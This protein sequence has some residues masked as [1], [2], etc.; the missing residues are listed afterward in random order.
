MF[1]LKSRN[2]LIFLVVCLISCHQTTDR[3]FDQIEQELS[4][5]PDSAYTR[6]S[7][8]A[9]KDLRPASRRARYALLMS[10]AMDKSYIDT[11]DD[12]LVQVAVNY[13]QRFGNERE[14]MLAYYSL[15]RVQR[16]AGK[17]TE[18]IITFLHTKDLA[19]SISDLHYLGLSTRNIA[20]LYGECN[21]EDSELQ[22]YIQSSDAFM[23]CGEVYYAAYSQLGEAR[24]YMAKGLTQYADS[25]LT[26]LEN[27]A[28]E[29]D[30][31]LLGLVLMDCALNLMKVSKGNAKQVIKLY[32]EADSLKVVSKKTVDYG[33]VAL[34]FEQLQKPDSADYY[35]TMARQTAKT[36][37]DST[38]LFNSL[39]LLYNSRR[40]YKT[41]NEHLV[42]GLEIH[43]Q[44]VYKK[45]NQQVAN[46]I[47]AHSQQKAA[48]HAEVA[49]YRLYLVFLSLLAVFAL[50]C[51][52][53]LVTKARRCQIREKNRIILEKE[54]RIDE[55]LANVQEISE[56]LQ[57]L[58]DNQSEMA[59]TIKDLMEEKIAIVKR[60][61]DA[62]ERVKNEPKKNPRDPY[63]YLDEDPLKKQTEEMQSFLNAL[64][65]IR[66][67]DTLFGVLEESV[68]KWRGDLMKKLRAACANNSQL[69]PK[70]SDDDLRILMLLYAGI[71]DRTIAF[72]MDM[73]CSAI[74]TR[75]SR[76]KER[77]MQNDIPDGL[78]FLQE[79]AQ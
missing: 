21:D 20:A 7:A 34:A 27:Y 56:Q 3:Q 64:N 54:Q 14:K 55:E 73:T 44:L 41:A 70:F 58:R 13:Y 69:R 8:I 57:D 37:L 4:F 51:V 1:L 74:R 65:Q 75:K 76:Y 63:R 77:L 33:T 60:C 79:L 66:K 45:E 49:R 52:L 11:D 43:N 47:S 19:E 67:D 23:S 22:Y 29:K 15:G 38:H 5:Q 2:L 39:Y 68:N 62:Y 32:K 72:L 31:Y 17:N 26:I 36:R 24:T 16:N 78:F 53:V 40:D 9:S 42:K 12:S 28:R 35:I 30:Q 10:L 61:A 71:P 46:A 6:L 50:L 25:V 59:K 48:R 18:A